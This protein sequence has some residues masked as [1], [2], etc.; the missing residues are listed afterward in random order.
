MRASNFNQKRN[1]NNYHVIKLKD[2]ESLK[3]SIN[4]RTSGAGYYRSWAGRST[5]YPVHVEGTTEGT[6]YSGTS[7]GI[8]QHTYMNVCMM[9]VQKISDTTTLT[10]DRLQLQILIW[11]YLL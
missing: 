10:D 11:F 9:Y 8:I 1:N 7:T 4:H 2:K 6:G 3:V 5:V